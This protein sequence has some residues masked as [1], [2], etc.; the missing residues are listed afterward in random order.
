MLDE[1]YMWEL[2]VQ[3]GKLDNMEMYPNESYLLGHGYGT[4]IRWVIARWVKEQPLP[5]YRSEGRQ[6]NEGG[7]IFDP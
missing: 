7:Y 5:T 3:D 2:G 4:W 1:Q 6:D